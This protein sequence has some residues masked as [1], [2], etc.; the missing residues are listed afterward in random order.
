VRR[1]VAAFDGATCRA[2]R[3]DNHPLTTVNPSPKPAP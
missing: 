2:A 3:H 1:P